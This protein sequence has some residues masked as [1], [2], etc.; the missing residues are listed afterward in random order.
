MEK[1]ITI[2]NPYFK[3]YPAM[4]SERGDETCEKELHPHQSPFLCS[5]VIKGT[6]VMTTADPYCPTCTSL[7]APLLP[8]Q[9]LTSQLCMHNELSIQHGE[10][11]KTTQNIEEENI[12]ITY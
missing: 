1:K 10:Y 6:I 7:H 3:N 4:Q 12:Q 11:T 5:T 9:K 8:T 2:I